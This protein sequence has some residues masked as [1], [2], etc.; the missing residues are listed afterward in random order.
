M[1]K[2]CPECGKPVSKPGLCSDCKGTYLK[3]KPI[4]VKLCPSL[5]Y[6]S[7]GK[8]TKFKDLDSLSEKLLKESVKGK[9]KLISG[10]SQFPD[11]LNKP[12]LSREIT[13][14]I[15]YQGEEFGVPINVD[16][17]LSPFASKI[18]TTYFQ[19]ILQLRNADS[20]VKN[21][22]MN[23]FNKNEII[24]NK[25]SG[26]DESI[27]YFFADKRKIPFVVNKLQRNF[28]GFASNNPQLFSYDK[29]RSKD[30]FRLNSLYILPKFKI[31]DVITD[32]E[33]LLFVKKTSKEISGFDLVKKKH[34]SMHFNERN[35]EKVV[36]IE[37]KWTYVT[38]TMPSLKVSH[39]DNFQE[40]DAQNPLN[41]SV[42]DGKKVRVVIHNN[43]LILTK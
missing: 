9:F 24:I 7:K 27:D 8:W 29:Q 23:L 4:K 43:K 25:I 17:T 5:R 41:I 3:F 10:L 37:Q 38:R 35:S 31:N 34:A 36:K 20:D 19:G 42:S 16:V 22:L 11:L 39:P 32:G 30:L 28:G 33:N 12:G 15:E 6:F 18:G 40:E 21:Y 14:M 13:C 2:F 26:R 1:K